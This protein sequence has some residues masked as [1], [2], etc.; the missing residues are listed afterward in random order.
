MSDADADTV[1]RLSSTLAEISLKDRKT[2]C[3]HSSKATGTGQVQFDRNGNLLMFNNS[4]GH[5]RP[6]AGEATYSGF[7][8][9]SFT[10]FQFPSQ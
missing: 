5:Y 10:P 3:F 1:I 6:I 4:S 2:E 7:A 8:Q 9:P